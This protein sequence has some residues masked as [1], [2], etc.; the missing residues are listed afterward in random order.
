MKQKSMAYLGF[1]KNFTRYMLFNLLR[2][3]SKHAGLQG[4]KMSLFA[5]TQKKNL[6]NEKRSKKIDIKAQ[7]AAHKKKKK[8]KKCLSID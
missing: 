6:K 3:R 8:K 4:S 2:V 5:S 1:Q 7:K